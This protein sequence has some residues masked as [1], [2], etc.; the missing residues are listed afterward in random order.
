MEG[1]VPL[2]DELTQSAIY[3][4]VFE[5]ASCEGRIE[6]L[7]PYFL[8]ASKEMYKARPSG[9]SDLFL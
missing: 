8:K 4:R 9:R 7:K 2:K 3:V 1:M 6:E 5:K